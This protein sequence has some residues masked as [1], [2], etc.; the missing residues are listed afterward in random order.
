MQPVGTVAA[1]EISF[2]RSGEAVLD[3]VS[4]SIPPRSR[5][6]VVGPNGVGKSTLL[7]VLAGLE[8]PD[9]GRVTR[10]PASLRVGYVPQE[11]DLRVGETLLTYLARRTG[12]ADAER[13]M[14][15]LAAV[16]EE[17]P[18][19]VGEYTEALETFLALGGADLHARAGAML[20]E[21]GLDRRLEHAVAALSGGE[22]ARVALAAVM[23]ARFDVYLLDEPTNDLDFDGL[24]RLE[25][26]VREAATSIVVVSHDRVFLDRTVEKILEFEPGTAKLAEYAGGWSEF[27]A[28]R[29]RARARHEQAYARYDE[30]RIRWTDAQR[31][32]RQQ[33][34]TGGAQAN[35]R[36]THA[37]MSKTRSATKRLERL[38]RNKVE[39]PW[40]PWRLELALAPRERSGDLVVALEQ[41][42][43]LRGEFRLGP[44]DFEL[45]WGERVAVVGPNGSGKTT[46][47]E[48]VLGRVPLAAGR[49]RIGPAVIVGDVVQRREVYAVDESLLATF[50]DRSGL[51]AGEARTLLAKFGLY[52]AH[53]LRIASTLS[54]GERTRAALAL[55]VARG[56]NC[57]V[58]DEPTNHLDLPAIEE[59]ETALADYAGTLLLV[60]HDRRFLERV[61]VTRTVAP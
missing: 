21:L 19:V 30:E 52:A 60:T 38:E 48:A 7:R 9:A 5:I 23:L 13:R 32:R 20:G 11:R 58:L 42:V 17:K 24:D 43:I 18:G 27:E 49:R 15:D 29:D 6:G 2:H 22:W 59:L 28:A 12:V 31:D 3:A 56:A 51:D 46:L 53:V 47:L 1:H 34:R 39:K 4:L 14:D 26:F 45:T 57:L 10:S 16:L 40:E 25:T 55:E 35:R 44:L 36:A 50:V 8:R 41:A 33:A 61:A 54:P 37:L